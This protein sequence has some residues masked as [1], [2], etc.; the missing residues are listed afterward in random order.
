M[1]FKAAGSL[2]TSRNA[3]SVSW[4]AVQNKGA[5]NREAIREEPLATEE[6]TVHT[7]E[8]SMAEASDT[9]KSEV[10]ATHTTPLLILPVRSGQQVFTPGEILLLTVPSAQVPELLAAGSI[11]VYGSLRGRAL[12]GIPRQCRRLVHC[13]TFEAELIAINGQ[14]KIITPSEKDNDLWGEKCC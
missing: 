6:V 2:S 11:H 9:L 1:H 13:L 10:Q 8:E 14:Y 3:T 12:A 4:L 7:V 5:V